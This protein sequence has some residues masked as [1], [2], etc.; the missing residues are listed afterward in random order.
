MIITPGKTDAF[1]HEPEENYRD[2]AVIFLDIDGVMNS[3]ASAKTYKTFHRAA[4]TAIDALNAIL[5]DRGVQIVISSTWRKI[6]D[7]EFIRGWLEG[8]GVKR[9]RVIG[10]TADLNHPSGRIF[11]ISD[12][13]TRY[14]RAATKFKPFVILDDDFDMTP[15]QDRFI[16]TDMRVG[17][18]MRD[19]ERAIQILQS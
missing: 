7:L 5:A 16:R 19:A 12:W 4:P 6:H 3:E 17:L 10:R 8:Q 18:T 9:Q 1:Y 15:H 2:R 14:W 13:L 11:E